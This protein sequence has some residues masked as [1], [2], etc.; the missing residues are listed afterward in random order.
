MPHKSG[1]WCTGRK[2]DVCNTFIRAMKR[3]YKLNSY[4]DITEY[5]GFAADEIKRS[6]KPTL[7]KKKWN[8][9]FPLI[10]WNITENEALTY[11]YNL[12]YTWDGLYDVF[13]RVSCVCCPKAARR[14]EKVRQHFPELHEKFAKQWP[15][16]ANE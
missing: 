9:S 4:T 10:D 8:V 16:S 15:L 12:G 13:R 1:G 14:E 7:A 3:H 11:C 2:Q 5:I 6:E